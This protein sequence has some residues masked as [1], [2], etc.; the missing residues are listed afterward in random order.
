[1]QRMQPFVISIL[2]NKEMLPLQA[3]ANYGGESMID[4][5]NFAKDPSAPKEYTPSRSNSEV[6]FSDIIVPEKDDPQH[7]ELPL[8]MQIRRNTRKEMIRNVRN[9]LWFN[10]A[11]K[12]RR[13]DSQ[14]ARLFQMTMPEFL[15]LEAKSEALDRFARTVLA[16]EGMVADISIHQIER[17]DG[18]TKTSAFV[19]ATTRPYVK[20]A[21]GNKNREWN[22]INSLI[23]WRKSWF[24]ILEG[25]IDANPPAEEDERSAK[26][27]Q[28]LIDRFT[29]ERRVADP[30]ETDASRSDID[31]ETATTENDCDDDSGD[32]PAAPRIMSI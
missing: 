27:W 17:E 18:K 31:D 12:E 24:S 4:T 2:S 10:I 13:E 16:S 7:K 30:S 19:M 11:M 29:K 32:T 5:V 8:F 22:Q 15:P 26:M 23:K 14:Y 28:A 25:A 6:V 9:R 21:L 1:M 3:A 20:G